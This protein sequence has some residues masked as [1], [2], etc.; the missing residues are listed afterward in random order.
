MTVYRVKLVEEIFSV[1]E[2][3]FDSRHRFQSSF[4]F[5]RAF[6]EYKVFDIEIESDNLSA[7]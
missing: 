6:S 4:S 1:I 2:E 3:K 5:L 7:A